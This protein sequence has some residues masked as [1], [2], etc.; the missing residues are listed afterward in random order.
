M[1][2]D[3]PVRPQVSVVV[4]VF[5]EQDNIAPLVHEITAALRGLLPFEIIYVDDC[6]T[7]AR[8]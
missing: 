6:S 1:T 4:P 7:R 5:N 2:L 8:S 3:N